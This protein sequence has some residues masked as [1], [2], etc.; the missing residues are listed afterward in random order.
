MEEFD[1][2]TIANDLISGLNSKEKEIISRRF[3]FGGKERETLE[4]I[5]K[6]FG[7]SR[8][9]IRQIQ[10]MAT[11]KIQQNLGKYK[12]V[13]EFFEKKFEEFEGVRKETNLL[14]E[15]TE[16]AKNEA[17]FLLSLWPNFERFPENKE[18]FAFWVNK[19]E[20]KEKLENLIKKV[21]SVLQEKKETLSLEEIAS[22]FSLKKEVLKEWIEISKRIGKDK[23]GFYGLK[24]WPEITPRGVRDKAYL[25]L[26]EIGKPL[27]FTEIAKFIEKANV[28]TVHNEL[29]KDPKFVLIG[30]G[31]YAL[32]E[33]GYEKGQVKDIIL[34]IFKEEKRPL[35]KD[36][37]VEKVLKQRMVKKSTILT[38]LSDKK[39]FLRDEEGRYYP[40]VEIA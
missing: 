17:F 29:I 14:S 39:Y 37:I 18:F 20:A 13:F 24:E 4:A 26:K 11:K 6:D 30:R 16:K 7:V 1:F 5:G 23:K 28:H 36:E 21:I 3:G 15:L 31:I 27:H 25:V 2:K 34:K 22:Y 10:E 32:A 9:R 40:K 19:K 38:N 35:T 12:D 33:W 8:E